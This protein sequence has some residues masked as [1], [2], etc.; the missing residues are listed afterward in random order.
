MNFS[1]FDSVSKVWSG[2]KREGIYNAEVSLG[3]LILEVLKKT[4]D[5]I[6]QVT[7]ETG[8]EMTC[9][10]MRE[11]TIKI[12]SHLMS[13]GFQ[14]GDVVGIIALNSEN[15]APVFFACLALGLPIN[16]LSPVMT[17]QDIVHMYSKTKPKI[18]FCDADIVEV[19]Q[20]SVDTIGSNTKIIT[21]LKKLDGYEFVGDILKLMK[22]DVA[23]FR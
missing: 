12:A 15:L 11:R 14:Q 21:F 7:V 9:H 18:I 5:Q 3:Y 17:E 8:Y 20:S 2:S 6:T 23:S 16:T 10:E 22:L 19:V 1:N 13:S 4:P